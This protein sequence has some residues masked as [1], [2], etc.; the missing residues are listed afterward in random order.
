MARVSYRVEQDV[1]ANRSRVL[2][3]KLEL[4]ANFP[5]GATGMYILGS[6]LVNGAEAVRITMGDT[7]ACGAYVSSQDYAGGGVDGPGGGWKIGFSSREMTVNHGSDGNA[8][9]T[10]HPGISL[11]FEGAV[12]DSMGGTATAALPQIP[13]TSALAVS[14]VELGRELVME[15]TRASADFEDTITWRCGA[16]SGTLA[17]RTKEQELRWTLPLDLAAQAPADTAVR[18]VLTV[19]TFLGETQ[20]GSQDTELLCPIPET[21]APSL[22]VA[23]EDRMGY[24]AQYGGYIQGQSQARVTTQAAGAYGST[25][26]G[27]SVKCGKLTGTGAEVAFALEDSGSVS[28]AVT[29]TDSRGRTASQVSAITVLPY[30][31]PWAVIR[32]A[33]RCDE[34]GNVQPDG[35]WMK[36]VFD[37]GVTA[38][39]GSTAQYA[40][41]CTVHGGADT[42]QAA[43]EEYENQLTVTGGQVLLPAGVDT[44]YDCRIQVQD[45]FCAAESGAVLVSVAF[46]LLD[47]CRAAKAVGIGMRAKNEGML[48]IGMDV[49]MSERRLGN[50][51]PPEQGTD[52]ATKAYV[53]ECIRLLREQLNLKEE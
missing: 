3:T 49:D 44:G 25:I 14:G 2:V 43:L 50:L 7:Y 11:Y 35:A 40:A 24:A 26:R 31:K 53:D 51:A 12:R 19:T 47:L 41:V 32:E 9:I 48:S 4:K 33:A 18:L 28:I 36:L 6:I 13:R 38:L 16:A 1:A 34:A 8:Q 52:A 23:V 46:A 39:E 10:I 20:A 21:V 17:E 15:L 27:I 45:R 30:Q 29:V 37:A 5:L 22:A 42:R